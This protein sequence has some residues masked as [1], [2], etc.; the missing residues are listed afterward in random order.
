MNAMRLMKFAPS[1]AKEQEWCPFLAFSV[2]ERSDAIEVSITAPPAASETAEA[3]F[4]HFAPELAAS[5][6]KEIA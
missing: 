2:R 3:L 1:L 6:T 5:K 4:D